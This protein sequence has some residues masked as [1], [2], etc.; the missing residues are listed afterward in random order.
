VVALNSETRLEFYLAD[1]GIMANGSIA[2]A[3]YPS[4]PP[5][6]LLRNI[7][8]S[9]AVRGFV[10]DPKMLAAL[11]GAPVRHW[12]LLTGSA[13]GALTLD[14]LRAQGRQALA[15]DAQL[16]APERRTF[17]GGPG[18]SVPDFG[19]HRRA[20]DGAGHAPGDRLQSRY[21]PGRA[22]ARTGGFHGGLSAVGAHRAA[23]GDRDAAHPRR[24]A[25]D[26]FRE[27][28]EAAAGDPQVRPTIL[29]APPRM[30]ER[31]YST[32][33]TELRKRPAAARQAFY[34]GLALGLAA[35]RYRRQGKPVP[36]RI[37][38]PLK[39]A[40]PCFSAKCACDSAGEFAWP[41]RARRRS[42][43]TWRS[44]TRRSACR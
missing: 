17:A 24:H 22:A 6:D 30:W 29:L 32:I 18:D 40:D 2:A 35:A 1:I 26:V 25:G 21:G 9:G 44:S 36:L 19:R 33:C 4:Y 34:G 23:R 39:L 14:E 10:E 43:K 8:Q 5:K 12:F 38:I 7:E 20:Q 31:I 11:R 3:L 15:A 27:P 37:R 42:A 16:G 41:P 28:A 13:E